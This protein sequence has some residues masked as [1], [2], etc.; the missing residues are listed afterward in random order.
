MNPEI[1]RALE[2]IEKVKAG[3]PAFADMMHLNELTD[4]LLDLSNV[5]EKA[6]DEAFERGRRQAVL[7][8][9][10]WSRDHIG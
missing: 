5:V 3:F 6:S 7:D 1:Q 8:S 4:A 9:R 2:H 10:R